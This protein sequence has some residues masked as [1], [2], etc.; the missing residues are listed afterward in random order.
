MMHATGDVV[1]F[2][3]AL[4]ASNRSTIAT[5]ANKWALLGNPYPSY[6]RLSDDATGASGTNYFL[7]STHLVLFEKY[8]SE[9]LGLGRFS[10]RF[11]FQ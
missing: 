8:S 9:Y 7:N 10:I 6:L 3:G 5:Y 11:I 4:R 1:A 2:T